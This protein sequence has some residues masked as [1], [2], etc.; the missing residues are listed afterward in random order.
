MTHESL[1]PH[2]LLE[3]GFDPKLSEGVRARV[4]DSAA[5]LANL[6]APLD[7][8]SKAAVLTRLADAVRMSSTRLSPNELEWARGL[9]TEEEIVGG[10]QD[11]KTTGGQRLADFLPDLEKA[12]RGDE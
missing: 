10:L 8:A 6:L 4:S 7:D 1:S 9:F 5:G 3:A 12:A 11:V 2:G